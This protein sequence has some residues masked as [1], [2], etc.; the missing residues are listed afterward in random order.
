M[1]SG[2]RWS[3]GQAIKACICQVR[4][5]GKMRKRGEERRGEGGC[6]C[7][8][9]LQFLMAK[10]TLP[11]V[12]HVIELSHGLNFPSKITSWIEPKAILDKFKKVGN[13]KLQRGPLI[14]FG[15]S[16]TCQ[17]NIGENCKLHFPQTTFNVIE[18]ALSFKQQNHE[19]FSVCHQSKINFVEF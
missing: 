8:K 2:M 18:L 4:Q 14:F 3:R 1:L 5:K 17:F 9:F 11:N 15:K 16:S 10:P 13:C 12:W 19:R 7:Y 6:G